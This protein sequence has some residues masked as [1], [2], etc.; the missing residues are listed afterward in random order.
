MWI[1]HTTPLFVI[2]VFV[3]SVLVGASVDIEDCYNLNATNKVG[4]L[5]QVFNKQDCDD[6]CGEKGLYSENISNNVF[7]G[8]TCSCP[9]TEEGPVTK[10]CLGNHTFTS[11]A[12]VGQT[13]CEGGDDVNCVNYCD[14]VAGTSDGAACGTSADGMSRYCS[15]TPTGTA[16]YC[17]DQ[18]VAFAVPTIISGLLNIVSA[19]TLLSF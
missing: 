5:S 1:S 10:Q 11:C 17:D 9:A 15:C 7:L 2:L 16:I 12:A 3:P 6:F 4:R 18:S 14:D 8:L 13:D 19:M